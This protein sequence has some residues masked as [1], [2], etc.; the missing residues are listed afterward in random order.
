MDGSNDNDAAAAKRRASAE[1]KLK[2]ALNAEG[3]ERKVTENKP[4]AGSHVVTGTGII[5]GDG[6]SVTNHIVNNPP[7]TQ[8]VVN[9]QTGVG[10]LTASQKGKINRIFKQW[11]EMRGIVRKGNAEYAALRGAFNTYMD[12]NKFDEIRQEDFEKAMKWLRRQTGIVLSMPSARKKLPD[13]RN[14]RYTAIM[15]RAKEFSDGEQR[16]RS[17]AQE[18][19]GSGS[20]KDLDDTQL[21][22][23][24]RHV[25]GWKRPDE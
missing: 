4:N 14:K 19:F 7:P 3:E 20:L 23:V 11:A 1:R 24:Y 25:F 13:W 16:F 21:D 9:V 2:D 18:R 6:N 5:I 15:A 10:V 8:T 12:V 22:A 17:Y